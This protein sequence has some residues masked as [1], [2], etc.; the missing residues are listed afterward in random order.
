MFRQT[1]TSLEKLVIVESPNKVIKIEGLLSNPKVIPDWS[2]KQGHLKCVGIGAEK[3]VAM[4]TTGH[5]MALKE[6]TWITHPLPPSSAGGKPQEYDGEAFPSSGTLAEYTLE[7]EPLPGR[8]IQET[9]ERY[10]EGKV[11]NVSE[12]ILATDPDR[13]GELIAVHALQTIKRLYP[14]LKVP[15]SRAYMHSITED[16]I[17][18]AMKERSLNICDYDLASAAETRHV[19]D[20]FFGFLGSSV[21]RAANS[22]MRSIGRVQTP[23]LI[24]INEREDKISAFLE[25]N[26]ST[27]VVEATCQ[28]PVPHGTTFSQVVDI[29]SDRRGAPSQ[30]NTAA[31]ANNCLEHWKL[32]GCHSFS[33]P[34]DPIVTPSKVPPPQPL[35]MAAAIT[36]LNRQMKLS[37]EMVSGYLQD[38]FQLGHITY[39]R[40]DSTRIDESALKDI[41]NA[42]KKNFGKEFLYRLEDRPASGG[43]GK[44]GKK[45]TKKKTAKRGKNS[46]TPV[47]NVEDAHEAIRPTNIN[48]QG[49]SLSLSP[50]TRAVYE[51]VRRQTLAAFMIPQVVEKIVADVKF[52]SGSGEKLTLTLGGKRVVEPGW[53]RAFH[54]GDSGNLSLHVGAEEGADAGDEGAPTMCSLSQEEFYAILNLRRV[55]NSPNQQHLFELR[56]PTIRENRPVPPMPHSE[57]TLIEELKRNG[58]GRPSTYPL[59][60]KTLLARGYIQVNAKGRCETTPVGRMLVETAKST[61]PSIVDLGFTASFEKQLDTVAKPHPNKRPAFL[62]STKISQADYVLSM[63]LSTFLNYVSEAAC[64]QRARIIERSMRL[65]RDQE[66]GSGIGDAEFEESVVAARRKVTLAST[67]LVTLP[68]TYNNFSTLQ[69]NLNEY[70]RHNFPPSQVNGSPAPSPTVDAPR[71]RRGG[72]GTSRGVAGGG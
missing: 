11:E 1:V 40:T 36:K 2:F 45:Q 43:D 28:F 29:H 70:L 27:F 39:P 53:T 16:G 12:I 41:Y 71:S 26:K 57:G 31:E 59:I 37:S 67:D 55:L 7:W 58:V 24:L 61:F 47:G 56:S 23:A 13:E 15:F 8:R 44:R 54:K 30:W 25:R 5:F 17:R 63:F 64:T 68:K 6:I 22:Q 46:G 48:V 42:V 33:I 32:D 60:V 62:R 38:L 18:K 14:K 50:E 35:T 69:R 20:R 72:A 19:M 66:G 65:K 49:D 3:A 10:I 4:A 9:L 51:L 21:V 52:V 34:H